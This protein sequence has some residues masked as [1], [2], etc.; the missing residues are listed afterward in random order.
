MDAE[1]AATPWV[2]VPDLRP[3]ARGLEQHFR[4]GLVQEIQVVAALQIQPDAIGDGG[5]DVVRRRTAGVVRGAF[6]A[7]DGAPGVQRADRMIH[8]ARMRARASS[9]R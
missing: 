9:V 2:E 8:L 3:D 7:V 4:A 6:A 5:V 1:G